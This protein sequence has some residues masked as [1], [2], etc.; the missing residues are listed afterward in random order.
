M[1]I[2]PS[3]LAVVQLFNM[4]SCDGSNVFGIWMQLSQRIPNNLCCSTA[5]FQCLKDKHTL[6]KILRY[7]YGM[8]DSPKTPLCSIKSY[9]LIARQTLILAHS[10]K[11]WILFNDVL[12]VISCTVVRLGGC[13][14]ASFFSL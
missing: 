7:Q 10:A 6:S 14:A 8:N 4:W 1:Q 9:N 2:A 3:R 5:F 11:S 12:I 13:A